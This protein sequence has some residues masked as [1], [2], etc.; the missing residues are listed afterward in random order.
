MTDA[1]LAIVVGLGLYPF[2]VLMVAL[3]GPHSEFERRAN[4]ESWRGE[5][6]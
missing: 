4:E 3:T 1:L 6:E 2:A 5:R